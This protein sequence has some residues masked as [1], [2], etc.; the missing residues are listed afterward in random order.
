[1]IEGISYNQS[2]KTMLLKYHPKPIRKLIPV[3]YRPQNRTTF[4]ANFKIKKDFGKTR[5]FVQEGQIVNVN[6][7]SQL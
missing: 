5:P 4:S 6:K 2:S 1:M 7:A 3:P